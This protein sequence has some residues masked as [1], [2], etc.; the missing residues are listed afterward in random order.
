VNYH[1]SKMYSALGVRNQ[2]NYY[3][4]MPQLR[5]ASPEMDNTCEENIYELIQAGMYYVDA[6]RE[7]L[8]EIVKKLIKNK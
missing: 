7:T 2:K 6:N 3:R 4:L 1:L 5:N 8:N